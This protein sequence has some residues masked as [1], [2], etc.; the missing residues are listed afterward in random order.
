AVLGGCRRDE[1]LGPPAIVYG[2]AECEFCKMIISEEAFASAVVIASAA[3]QTH[4]FAFD[5][6]GCLLEFLSQPERGDVLRSYVHDYDTH[7]WLDAAQATFVRG[8]SLQTPMASHVA[9]CATRAGA[10]RL[11]KRYPGSTL[12]FERLPA[13]PTAQL[14]TDTPTH[15]R[16]TP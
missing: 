3:G 5:D 7:A 4:K 12:R 11:L 6:I 8:E 10:E 9:A 2:Q 16:T 13:G 15:E 1:D 14:A